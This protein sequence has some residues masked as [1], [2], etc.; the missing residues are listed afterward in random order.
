MGAIQFIEN[1]DRTALTISDEDFEIKVEQAVSTIA[2]RNVHP[3]HPPSEAGPVAGNVQISEKSTLSQPQVT[4]QNTVAVEPQ[5]FP[6]RE[7]PYLAQNLSSSEDSTAVDGLL[8]TMKRPLSSLGKIFSDDDD[9]NRPPAQN[10]APPP[11]PPRRLSP[12]MFQ[13]P[14]HSED[15]EASGR[16]SQEV[17][18]PDPRATRNTKAEDAAAAAARQA[19]AE[20]AQAQRIQQAEHQNVVE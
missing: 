4:S 17:S 11:Q 5:K 10:L 14:R 2:E 19:S 9:T 8:R 18:S 13:P 12:D 1:L 16:P 3:V 20:A 7:K 15:L 6:F